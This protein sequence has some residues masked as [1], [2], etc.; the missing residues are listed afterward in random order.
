MLL[1]NEAV[2]ETEAERARLRVCFTKREKEESGWKNRR[3]GERERERRENS[4][5]D[6]KRDEI[7]WVDRGVN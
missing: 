4:E 7:W 1:Q 3:M 5:K 2:L 6:P